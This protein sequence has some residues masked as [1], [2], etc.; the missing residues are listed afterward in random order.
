MV[1]CPFCGALETDRFELEGRR[2]LVFA[3]MFTPELDPSLPESEIDDR[4][5]R[6]YPSGHARAFF[7]GTCDRLHYFVTVGAGARALTGTEAPAT[8]GP[9]AP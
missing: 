7:R 3:C 6:D 4:L 5:R 2:F 8:G 1:T 9:A